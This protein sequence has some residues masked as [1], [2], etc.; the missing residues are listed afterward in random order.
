MAATGN[1]IMKQNG[2]TDIDATEITYS[3]TAAPLN[4]AECLTSSSDQT[5][6]SPSLHEET[7]IPV[8]PV[9][10]TSGISIQ[11][12]KLWIGNLDKRLTE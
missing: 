4:N 5:R 3:K 11:I 7:L 8:P 2:N 1:G 6:P 12:N 9:V 10:P